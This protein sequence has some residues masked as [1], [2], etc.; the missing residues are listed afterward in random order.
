MN[1][2]LEGYEVFPLDLNEPKLRE[3]IDK[4]W[5][6]QS[7]EYFGPPKDNENMKKIYK[8]HT[9]F[10]YNQDELDNVNY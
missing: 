6:A 1:N 4:Y 5:R 3:E 7:M 10:T 8:T 9:G 2:T